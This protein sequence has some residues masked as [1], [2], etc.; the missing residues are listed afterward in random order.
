LGLSP[1][2]AAYF[3]IA[4]NPLTAG[5]VFPPG[6]GWLL[7]LFNLPVDD[8]WVAARW[9]N[10]ALLVFSLLLIFVA[11]RIATG[12]HFAGA[13]ATLLVGTSSKVLPVFSAALS[14]PAFLAWTLLALLMLT[15]YCRSPSQFTVLMFAG[16]ATGMAMLTR[17]AGA[18]LIA[19]CWTVVC[20]SGPRAVLAKLTHAA[21]ATLIALLPLAVWLS[22]FRFV[23][24]MAPEQSVGRKFAFLGNADR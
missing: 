16:L 20:L 12:S 10:P 8:L 24:N 2:S 22:Y 3:A 9:T 14:E 15:H 17:Y 6:Y 19:V 23:L 5:G 18:P 11:T 13:L 7:A 1:D 21:L 4:N